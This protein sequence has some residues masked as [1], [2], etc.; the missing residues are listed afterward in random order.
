MFLQFHGTT[1]I[2]NSIVAENTAP[3]DPDLDL[4]TTEA[5]DYSLIGGDPMLGPL[6]DNGGP[7]LTHLP[8]EG[9]PAIDAGSEEFASKYTDQRGW[10][11]RYG[12]IDV[13]AVEVQPKGVPIAY[14]DG[15]DL[16]QDGGQDGGPIVFDPMTND[17]LWGQTGAT[18][19]VSRLPEHGT[20][21]TNP[22]GTYSYTPTPGFFGTDSLNYVVRRGGFTS[23]ETSV[24][25]SVLSPESM[26]VSTNVDELDADYSDG[27]L[28]L[29]EAL[30]TGTQI[31]FSADLL[32]QTIILDGG[33]LEIAADRTILGLGAPFLTVSG[34][35]K[36]RVF[37]I[38]E[39]AVVAMDGLTVSGGWA[40]EGG[41]IGN[42]G[43]LALTNAA[44]LGNTAYSGG[45]IYNRGTATIVDSN[46]SYNST[47]YRPE[48][49]G[50]E[51]GRGA[52][53]YSDGTLSILCCTFT[54]NVVHGTGL[55]PYSQEGGG[56]LYN[57]G[58]MTV[59]AST[60]CRNLAKNE[61][62]GGVYNQASSYGDATLTIS[63]STISGN[64]AADGGGVYAYG[65][66]GI[67]TVTITNSTVSGNAAGEDTLNA[68]GGIYIR[69]YDGTAA[70][71]LT[72]VTVT[73]NAAGYCGGV[74][75]YPP[76]DGTVRMDFTNSIIAGNVS[77]SY[78][79]LHGDLSP[80][81]G[82]NIIGGDAMLGPLADNGGSTLTHL[83]LPGSPVI[84]A[85]NDE[86]IT[87]QTD[88]RGWNRFNGTVDIGAVEFHPPLLGDMN[89]DRI[90]NSTDLDVIRANW[91]RTV[92][93]GS[94]LD[95][96]AS[97]DGYV[98]SADLDIVRG[99]W[100]ATAPAGAGV[101]VGDGTTVSPREEMA[102]KHDAT[103]AAL[104]DW[105]L[106]HAHRARIA[107]AHAVDAISREQGPRRD[108]KTAPRASA[109]DLTMIQWNRS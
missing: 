48:G 68:A 56:A 53:I 90:V 33:T 26:V 39:E 62:G 51:G 45:G 55:S 1:T 100:G 4:T 50:G 42:Y 57:Q 58:T 94:L 28:S 46:I 29:R 103:D 34:N 16:D 75:C 108:M 32:E 99:N 14:P 84:D 65:Y 98:G 82:F 37:N 79:D 15:F 64:G 85:G 52:G 107:W 41:G 91:G 18:V 105:A 71:T 20:L 47:A 36:C 30:Q 97:G 11:R 61:K 54:G 35:D 72:N 80:E 74:F 101:S 40:T 59:D 88:Q 93:I 49:G 87:A 8:L 92:P 43:T 106:S 13:G 96:D 2:R 66:Y 109:I 86:A 38:A 27:D 9:S 67:S 77:E 44:L 70:L 89:L 22:D 12:T 19:S 73:E 25:F 78:P 63:N 104:R 83:P 69:S 24:V 76:Y 81:S 23:N 5:D 31:Q 102:A 21:L 60:I 3:T 7:T 10:N 95:G 6:A 17:E